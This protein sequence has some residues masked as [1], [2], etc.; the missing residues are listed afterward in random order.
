M[1]KLLSKYSLWHYTS[2]TRKFHVPFCSWNLLDYSHWTLALSVLPGLGLHT[3]TQLPGDHD[4]KPAAITAKHQKTQC[5]NGSLVLS[6][7]HETCFGRVIPMFSRRS[8][9][10]PM[11]YIGY[12]AWAVGTEKQETWSQCADPSI[13]SHQLSCYVKHCQ[14]HFRQLWTNRATV[15]GCAF[16]VQID[17]FQC[18]A[19]W[20]PCE[21]PWICERF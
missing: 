18:W 20:N 14:L 8:L 2:C 17:V 16:E 11:W 15:L 1:D 5:L 10:H 3:W 21:Y 12:L 13:L 9:I 6:R 4:G 19:S 7:N